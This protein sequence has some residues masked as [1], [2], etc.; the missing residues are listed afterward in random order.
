MT[1]VISSHKSLQIGLVATILCIAGQ[2]SCTTLPSPEPPPSGEPTVEAA[3]ERLRDIGCEAG[4]PTPD[5]ATCEEWM[6][7]LNDLPGTDQ[8]LACIA[9]ASTC[10]AADACGTR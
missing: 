1:R 8:D 5:G 4:E 10:E 9:S 3:C 2:I 6:S 7:A